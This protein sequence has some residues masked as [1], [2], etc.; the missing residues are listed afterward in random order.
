MSSESVT[1]K[2]WSQLMKQRYLDL[3]NRAAAL[4]QGETTQEEFLLW[5][6]QFR[7]TCTLKKARFS[8]IVMDDLVLARLMPS[9]DSVLRSDSECPRISA[10]V[11]S[12]AGEL[13][14]EALCPD[15]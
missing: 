3:E 8:G 4:I 14:N 1:M 11:R 2:A 7:R 15:F 6:K 9:L 13:L 5:V 10:G 12:L